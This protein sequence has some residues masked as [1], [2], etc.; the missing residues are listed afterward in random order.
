MPRDRSA[1]TLGVLCGVLVLAAVL[2]IAFGLPEQTLLQHRL[3]QLYS[4]PLSGALALG[5][6]HVAGRLPRLTG[7]TRVMLGVA[8]AAGVLGVAGMAI[9][10]LTGLDALL[11]ASQAV[12]WLGLGFALLW[13]VAQL[14]R[15]AGAGRTFGLRPVDDD[16]E[17]DDPQP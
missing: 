5:V 8:T 3:L 10:V 6:V 15:R 2:M 11:P 7:P 1:L 12:T 14:P 17:D 16:T 9:G 4:V 13:L